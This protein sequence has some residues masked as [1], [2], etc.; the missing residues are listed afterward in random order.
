MYF[1]LGQIL[2][3]IVIANVFLSPITAFED[4]GI[5]ALLKRHR[6]RKRDAMFSADFAG[7]LTSVLYGIVVNWNTENE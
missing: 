6:N 5:S 3:A 2:H 1:L 7:S 4:A